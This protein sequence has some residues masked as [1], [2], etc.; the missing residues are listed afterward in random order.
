MDSSP[1]Q[2]DQPNVIRQGEELDLAKLEAYLLENMVDCRSPLSIKQFRSG[3]SNLTYM[4]ELTTELGA[5]KQFVLRR[6]PFGN[7]VKTAHDMSREF[8][9]LSALAPKFHLAPKPYLF[10]DD[11]SIIGDQFYVMQR[12]E[13]VILRGGKA[14]GTLKSDPQQVRRVDGLLRKHEHAVFG[15]GRTQLCD[16]IGS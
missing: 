14:A 7:Q 10:C 5:S 3:Y 12:C 2:V 1:L 16:Q 4:L 11:H 13:G 15:V 9:V 8:R 6:P